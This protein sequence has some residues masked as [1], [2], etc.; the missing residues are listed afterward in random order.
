L[1]TSHDTDQPNPE[2]QADAIDENRSAARESE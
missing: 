1:V 2:P